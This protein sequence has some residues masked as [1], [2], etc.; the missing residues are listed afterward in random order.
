MTTKGY[1]VLDFIIWRCDD[2][3]DDEGFGSVS[4]CVVAILREVVFI[5]KCLGI[6]DWGWPKFQIEFNMEHWNISYVGV[7]SGDI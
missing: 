7:F 2:D 1:D 6:S 3:D 4:V 5:L